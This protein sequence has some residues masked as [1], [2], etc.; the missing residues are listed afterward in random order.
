MPSFVL[1]VDVDE[2]VAAVEVLRH[3]GLTGRPVVVG[4]RGDPSKRGVV[5]TANYEARR[6]GLRSGMPLRTAVRKCPEAVFL[7]VDREA[8]ER[9]SR[10]VME[11][12]GEIAGA[13]EVWGWD[14]A[15]V[16]M[17]GDPEVA[18]RNIQ[19]AVSKRTG[20]SCSVGIGDNK[21]RAKMASGFAKP[22][23]VYRL[24]AREWSGVMGGRRTEELW[25]IGT[26]SARKL[27]ELGI[28]EVHE[29]AAA[30]EEMLSRAFGPRTGP[31]LIALGRGDDASPVS[32]VPR[33][34]RSRSVEL[35]FDEDVED[36]AV[37]GAEITRMALRLAEHCESSDRPVTG[38]TVKIRLAPFFTTT[39][40]RR[41][42][43]PSTDAEAIVEAAKVALGRFELDRPVRLV[44]VKVDLG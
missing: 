36:P 28:N 35:T 13:L 32:S 22:A 42:A 26:K 39:R 5:S 19:R 11:V 41:L 23:G 7:P 38:V 10:D 6:Y 20:L 4:G 37:I 34:A 1:H 8:Y 15:F 17:E 31:W 2:F 18:A 40:S 24:T 43:E 16:E 30:D 44:G 3:P 12:L 9:A 21:L 33:R 14:E 25:G 27:S 29:L